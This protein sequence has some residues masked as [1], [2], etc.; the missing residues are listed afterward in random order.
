MSGVVEPDAWVTFIFVS[1]ISAFVLVRVAPV[2]GLRIDPPMVMVW[3]AGP[4]VS[5][6]MRCTPLIVGEIVFPKA[7]RLEAVPVKVRLLSVR[8]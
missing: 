8:R 6:A 5:V 1:W 3:S 4:V 7:P 2:F